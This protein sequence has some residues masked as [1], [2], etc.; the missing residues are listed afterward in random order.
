M[1]THICDACGNIVLC[2][3]PET[4]GTPAIPVPTHIQ[5]SGGIVMNLPEYVPHWAT[6]EFLMAD[7]QIEGD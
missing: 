5:T 4:P 6:P 1:S 3:K 7:E 2:D